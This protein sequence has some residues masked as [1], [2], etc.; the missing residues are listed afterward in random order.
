MEPAD[1][2]LV[3]EP[4]PRWAPRLRGLPGAGE[5]PFTQV[6]IASEIVHLLEEQSH[7]L[8]LV[9]L[10]ETM[11]AR[12]CAGRVR[13]GSDLLRR[14]PQ[15]QV[16]FLLDEGLPP[17]QRVCWEMGVGL[18]FVGPRSLPAIARTM[19]RFL[20][21]HQATESPATEPDALAWLPW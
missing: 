10:R 18:V 15:C 12:Q 20:D 9:A 17:W 16:A 5:R 11:S 4:E 6:R 8:V 1:L 19:R 21:Q 3:Y 2:C 13:Q 7:R 14:W